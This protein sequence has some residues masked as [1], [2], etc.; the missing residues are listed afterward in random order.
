MS[1]ISTLLLF[2]GKNYF[3]PD[4]DVL[5][6]EVIISQFGDRDFDKNKML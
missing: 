2:I 6:G 5:D 4:Q 1:A 3:N